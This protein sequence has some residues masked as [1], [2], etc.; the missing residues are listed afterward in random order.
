MKF[1]YLFAS[2]FRHDGIN[3]K[4]NGQISALKKYGETQFLHLGNQSIFGFHLRGI[5]HSVQVDRIF[6]RYN[7]KVPFLVIWLTCLSWFK[8]IFFEHNILLYSELPY[9]KRYLELWM[10][11]VL[12]IV[13]S[14]GK[15]NHICASREIA[16]DLNCRGISKTHFVQN[17]YTLP[18]LSNQ[19]KNIN[20]IQ[21]VLNF[22]ITKLAVFTGNGYPW[23]GLD[24]VLDLILQYPEIQLLVLGPYPEQSPSSQVLYLGTVNQATLYALYE[25][26]DF[27]I[28]TFAWDRIGTTQGSPLKTREY[29]C[30]GLPIL[31]NYD[32]GASDIESLNP[33]VFTYH[34]NKDALKEL[35][36]MPINKSYLTQIA[37]MELAWEKIWKK[38]VLENLGL[39]RHEK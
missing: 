14:F 25:I 20:L 1:L 13:M 5:R 7:P 3:I 19:E 9:L 33:Y 26:A 23:H 37:R 17:G 24:R 16:E 32:D 36:Q 34:K 15:I 21:R 2:N 8:P 6:F 12:L 30:H 39:L 35:L 11:A 31:V 4:V 10:H 18:E 22:K 28:S 27:G 38:T 29:L